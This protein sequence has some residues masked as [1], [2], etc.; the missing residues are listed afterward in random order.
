MERD[1][2]YVN[3]QYPLQ[4]IHSEEAGRA[5]RK[6]ILFVTILLT[7]ITGIEVF[8]GVVADR[9][10]VELWHW[11]KIG[12]VLLTL[13]KAGY[14][15][16]VFMHLGDEKRLLR[17]FILIPYFFFM[18]YLVWLVLMEGQSVMYKFNP[19]LFFENW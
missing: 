5:I 18:F 19:A 4:S 7:V 15:V 6:K 2:L 3:D 1:D 11:I 13:L 9:S 8:I 10:N 16:M 14:I 17:N 12:Y